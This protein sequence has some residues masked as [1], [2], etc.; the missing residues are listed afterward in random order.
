MRYAILSDVHGRRHRLEAVLADAEKRKSDRVV[1]LGDAGGD[2]CLALLSNAGALAVFGNY[3]VSGWRRLAPVHRTWV[4]SWPPLL[5]E[6]GFLAVHAAPWWPEGL[7]TVSDFGAWL[8]RTAQ[9]WR[10]LFPYLTED[11]DYLWQAL[12][13]LEA[14]GKNILFHGHTHLQAIWRCGPSGRLQRVRTAAVRIEAGHRYLVGVGSVGMP[15]E[16]GW[17]A[18]TMYDAKDNRVE[19]IRL[20]RR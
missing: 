9:P 12:V 7:S 2:E 4:R 5:A 16:G 10:A 15:E 19:Q 13:E 3:E 20:D 8:K 18:Y 17:A 6:D 14:A 11:E 1:S